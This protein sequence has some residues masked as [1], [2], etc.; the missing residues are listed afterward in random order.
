VHKLILVSKILKDLQ[1]NPE[2]LCLEWVSA[3]EGPRFVTL[4]SRFTAHV[5]EL[6]P[7]G[8]PGELELERLMVRLKA[9]KM[10]LEGKRCRMVIARQA[11]FRKQ[12]NT[13]I[14]I[15]PGHKLQ[16]ELEKT[17]AEE[18]ATK[19]VLLCLQERPY[20]VDELTGLLGV[21]AETVADCF[22]KLEKKQLVEP[23]RLLSR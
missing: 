15:P 8:S 13:Y 11:R 16:G 21:S 20:S 7:L 18:T 9:A 23:E 12:G 19:G 14:E 17:F 10:A 4:I 6:G 5:R 1:V 3:A 2:R 22:K